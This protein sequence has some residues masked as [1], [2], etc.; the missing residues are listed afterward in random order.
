MGGIK[1]LGGDFNRKA[2][3]EFYFGCLSLTPID[4]IPSAPTSSLPRLHS[5]I[6][7]LNHGFISLDLVDERT[8]QDADGRPKGAPKA[9]FFEKLL[10]TT[11]GVLGERVVFIAQLKDG[12]WLVAKCGRR[13]WNR[14]CAVRAQP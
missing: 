13:T 4:A 10:R 6:Y 14:M 3:A 11:L 8:I 12:K 7:S 5:N 9:S 2:G 1:I